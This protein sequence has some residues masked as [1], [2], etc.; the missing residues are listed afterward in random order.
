MCIDKEKIKRFAYAIA[1]P[2]STSDTVKWPIRAGR[3]IKPVRK[4]FALEYAGQLELGLERYGEKI[5]KMSFQNSSQIWRTSHHL[6]NGW[7]EAGVSR[8]DIA[9]K[10]DMLLQGISILSNGNDFVIMGEHKLYNSVPY[11]GSDYLDNKDIMKLSGLLWAYCETI[12]FVAREI[13]CEYHGPYIIDN[14]NILIERNYMN[15]F[16]EDLWSQV[17]AFK[18]I[19][20][21][22]IRTIHSKDFWVSFDVY[23]NLFVN[24]GD[25][26][27]SFLTGQVFIDEK[28]A[29]IWEIYELIWCTTKELE[30]MCEHVNK[31]DES[32]LLW[33]YVRIF[34]YRKKGLAQALGMQWEP[35][36]ELKKKF[37]N[38]DN[39]KRKK[40]TERPSSEV[41][42]QK[43]DFSE[44]L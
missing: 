28:P 6:I 42:A 35:D 27:S 41:L 1:V 40:T 23:N 32:T 44:E 8:K 39:V 12:Y 37:K 38:I 2:L 16:P 29:T 5:W 10:V 18:N 36:D 15:L 11:M 9:K 3:A 17:C 20:K 31:M 4:D 21:I 30:R 24:H 14:D 25:F 34:W 13:G 26:L 43:Y 33:Q 7:Q 19:K 22:T